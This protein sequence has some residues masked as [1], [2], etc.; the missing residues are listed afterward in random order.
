MGNF[1]IRNR[2]TASGRRLPEYSPGRLRKNPFM[3]NLKIRNRAYSIGETTSGMHSGRTA[4]KPIHGRRKAMPRIM[5]PSAIC[6][7]SSAEL[8]MPS[9]SH[10]CSRPMQPA[11]TKA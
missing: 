3:R 8:T 4:E 2:L 9:E 5:M 11:L 10:F 6:A 1:K 7:I